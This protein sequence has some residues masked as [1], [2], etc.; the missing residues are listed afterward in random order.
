MGAQEPRDHPIRQLIGA[1]EPRDHLVTTAP[2]PKSSRY[3]SSGMSMVRRAP[4]GR[5]NNA[6]RRLMTL[7]VGQLCYPS[8]DNAIHR[9]TGAQEPRDHPIRRLV[10][11]HE[12]RDHLV[13]S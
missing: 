5:R 9:V 7:P 3:Q 10:G 11:A 12:P 4:S 2:P 13:T 1:H 6:I 8:V